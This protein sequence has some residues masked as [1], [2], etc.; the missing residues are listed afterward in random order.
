MDVAKPPV[1][2][3]FQHPAGLK[4]HGL[5]LSYVL[6][7]Y[8]TGLLGLFSA[9]W[10]VNA[11]SVLLLGHSMTIAAYLI[12]ECAHNT[13]FKNNDNNARLGSFLSWVCGACYGTYEDMRYKHFRHHV[14]NDDVVWFD[15]EAFFDE[16]PLILRVTRLLEWFYIPAHDLLMHGIMTFTSFI[17]PQRR[18]Q[19]AHNLAAIVVRGGLFAALCWFYPK[20]AVLY[21]IAYILMITV[22]RFMDFIQHDYGYHTNLFEGQR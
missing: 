1:T 6:L 4:Y 13:V 16:H 19:R 7:A 11:G 9:T 18:D 17:I 3:L 2:V 5:A 12:H 21:A 22:L 8:G 20:V 10:Y 14:D 15:Y